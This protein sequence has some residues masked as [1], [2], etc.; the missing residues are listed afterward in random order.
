M[1]IKIE[2]TPEL[3][4]RAARLLEIHDAGGGSSE[5]FT[6]EELR[7]LLVAPVAEPQGESVWVFTDEDGQLAITD[8]WDVAKHLPFE[9]TRYTRDQPDLTA[10]Q[11]ENRI[12]REGMKGDYDLDAWLEWAA[13]SEA[14][15]KDLAESKQDY[16]ELSLE[17]DR[18]LDRASAF[19]QRHTELVGLLNTCSRDFSGIAQALGKFHDQ[20][21][22]QWCG[23]LDDSLGICRF[24]K[25]ELDAAIEAAEVEEGETGKKYVFETEAYGV[26]LSQEQWSAVH[27]VFARHNESDCKD[28]EFKIS[29]S[30]INGLVS[31][32][33]VELDLARGE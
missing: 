23:Y 12:L 9:T 31:E 26:A 22:E 11:E 19:E 17:N 15:R 6:A 33:L 16:R 27:G 24:R 25:G 1:T 3:L 20:N 13:T 28:D 32:I 8:R 5:G 30:D 21:R 10:L 18:L 14:L 7:A 4:S 2:I 29:E